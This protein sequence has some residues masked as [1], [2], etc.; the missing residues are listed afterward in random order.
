MYQLLALDFIPFCQFAV[1]SLSLLETE[2]QIT[3]MF[4][5]MVSWSVRLNLVDLFSSN[6]FKMQAKIKSVFNR[7]LLDFT[8]QLSSL[9]ENNI[10]LT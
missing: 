9:P 8:W 5:L 2:N 3:S 4:K 1:F 6:Y 10:I 7:Q